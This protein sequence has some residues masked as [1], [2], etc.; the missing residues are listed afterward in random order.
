MPRHAGFVM[1]A[2]LK[3]IEVPYNRG[4][5]RFAIFVACATFVLIIAGAL[6]T[7]NDAGLSIPDW[8]RSFG[9]FSVPELHGGIQYEWSHRA[10]AGSI[11]LLTISI[12]AWTFFADRRRW[13][14]WL[15]IAGLGTVLT[16][17]ILG[18][19]T[20]LL[21]QPPWVSSAHAA[22]AQTFFC[23]AVS[24][25]V[26]TGRH[27]VEE[28][29]RTELDQRR[30]ALFTLT[31]LS[32]FVLYV[33]LILGAMF[34]HHGMSWW[35]H[36]VNAAVVAIVLSWTAVRA[37]SVY[38]HVEAVRRPAIAML[39]LMVAQLCLG[40]LAFITRVMWGRDAAQPELPMVIATVIHVAVGALLLATTVVLAI[41]VWRHVPVA[42]EERVPGQNPVAA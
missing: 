6:V 27:W 30:P 4:L 16:Q 11:I 26:F 14:K 21:M 42:F 13:M 39:G 24:I 18:G 12:A 15:A 38:S 29:P 31:L 41:Q 5:H 33:Q 7:S 32:I 35:P 10:I 25:A 3:G 17:A 37:I 28:H 34:R 1:G 23:I 9:S 2:I 40:F 8:P 36:V 19:L 22:V 20:V